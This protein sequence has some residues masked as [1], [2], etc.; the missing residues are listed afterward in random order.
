LLR[1]FDLGLCRCR[2]R[3]RGAPLHRYGR[4]GSGLSR[5][6]QDQSGG[7]DAA[8]PPAMNSAMRVISPSVSRVV[9]PRE[10]AAHC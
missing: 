1:E 10:L 6:R 5:L 8:A 7:D 4:A 3:V 2:R 9:E